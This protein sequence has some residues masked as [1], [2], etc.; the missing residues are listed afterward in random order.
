MDTNNQCIES[1]PELINCKVVSKFSLFNAYF[2][3][4]D[5]KEYL[6]DSLFIKHQV[7]VHFETEY[8]KPN[9]PYRII[10]CHVRKRDVPKFHA[11]LQELQHKMIFLG[12]TDYADACS[13]IWVKLYSAHEEKDDE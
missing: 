1:T 13:K 5:T 12:Y 4:V 2:I 3:F 10:L 8:S 11:A 9:S 7:R 6:A